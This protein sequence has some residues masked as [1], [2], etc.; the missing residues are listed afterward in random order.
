MRDATND[1]NRAQDLAG[2]N[3]AESRNSEQRPGQQ[4][5]MPALRNVVLVVQNDQA[6]SDGADKECRRRDNRHPAEDCEPALNQTP[7]RWRTKSLRRIEG[8]PAVLSADGWVDGGH[9]GHA[10]RDCQIA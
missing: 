1:L 2:E 3:I 8:G 10:S 7:E 5:S 6:L 4:S 9:F